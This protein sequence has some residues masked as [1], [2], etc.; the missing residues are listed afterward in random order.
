MQQ[1]G[2]SCSN[3]KAIGV[4]PLSWHSHRTANCLCPYLR[5]LLISGMSKSTVQTPRQR[6]KT[7]GKARFQRPTWFPR[8]G[9]PLPF[10]RLLFQLL[11]GQENKNK[12]FTTTVY[13]HDQG[14]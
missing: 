10:Q 8:P 7:E 5:T 14:W 11:T 12:L 9:C 4:S 2:K 13:H 3:S 6:M 1:Q